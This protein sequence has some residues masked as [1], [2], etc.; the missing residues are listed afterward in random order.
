MSGERRRAAEKRTLSATVSPGEWMSNCSQYPITLAKD[1]GSLS[2]PFTV[3]LPLERPA[4]FL[5]ACIQ[6]TVTRTVT[7]PG[8]TSLAHPMSTALHD[9]N[10]SMTQVVGFHAKHTV[11]QAM[12]RYTL[13]SG[14]HRKSAFLHCR[15]TESPTF[16]TNLNQVMKSKTQVKLTRRQEGCEMETATVVGFEFKRVKSSSQPPT[17]QLCTLS[18]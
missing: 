10:F 1:A 15:G 11:G 9:R 2:Y 13:Y 16:L 7:S 8:F 14:S 17:E 18:T 5:S 4:V 6:R 3:T 12:G